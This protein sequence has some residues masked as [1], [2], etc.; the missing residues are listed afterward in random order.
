MRGIR[1]TIRRQNRNCSFPTKSS[2]RKTIF[3]KNLFYKHHSFTDKEKYILL[4]KKKK[5]EVC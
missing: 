4:K 2:F 1:K 5:A 3:P